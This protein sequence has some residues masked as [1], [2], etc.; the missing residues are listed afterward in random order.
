MSHSLSP[1]HLKRYKDLGR[2]LI[3]Y[4]RFDIISRAGLDQV[5]AEE[6]RPPQKISHKVEELPKDL[7]KLGPTYV[8]L[9]QFLSTRSDML[10]PEYIETLS[11]LQDKAEQ[12]PFEK[13][14]QIVTS[15]L[16]LPISK[17][18]SFFDRV[19]LAAA[20]LAQVHRAMLHDGRWVAVKVQR[21]D[22][23]AQIVKDLDVFM[24]VAGFLDRH[25]DMAKRYMV[26]TTIDEFRKAI[27]GE[28][29]FR[30]EAQNLKILGENLKNYERIVVPSPIEEYTTSKVLTMDYIKGQKVTSIVPLRRLEIN[31]SELAE[32]LFLA[33]LQQ[34]LI[35][36]FY[37]ADPHPGNVFLTEDGRLALIDLG[38]VA[39]I[40]ESMRRK[41]LRLTLSISEGNADEAV[42]YAI[43]IGEKTST[44]NETNLS[45]RVKD[46]IAQYQRA[47]IT[48]IHVGRMILE[49]LKIAGESGFRFPSELALL[50]KCLLNLDNIG[51]TLDPAFNPNA[52]IRRYSG[53]L[54][55]QKFMK[56]VSRTNL[57]E[58]IIDSTELIEQ[59]PKRI[60]KISEILANNEFRMN[61][62]AIDEKY[63]MTGFQKVANRMAVGVILAGIIIGAA[64]MM[65][66]QTPHF[67]IFGYP[68]IAM[69]F[70]FI[71]AIGGL[72]L[73]SAI[74]IGDEHSNKKSGKRD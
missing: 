19:P 43:E 47:T 18:F 71:A 4:G 30:Q 27:L 24:E 73:A 49:L 48:Q 34:I 8:K 23:R 42:E 17:V 69:I 16:G 12:F 10:P 38:M 52:T 20:S 14:E 29:D 33:Y 37:H 15:E 56:S 65:Q 35:D 32:E 39:V 50:G 22:I 72:F 13:V 54:F 45:R 7:E 62:R 3:K 53:R 40:S 41:L 6:E 5:I 44:F 31:G 58:L 1:E 51:R 74:L 25:T 21:P 59:L 11:R 64:L 63:L 9:G 57:Y 70:F 28:L 36:G 67:T 66:V 46:L 68:G 2:L 60:D 55:R 26:G 61:V